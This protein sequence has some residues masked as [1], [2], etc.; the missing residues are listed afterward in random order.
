MDRRTFMKTA[1]VATSTWIFARPSNLT[2]QSG[3]MN[4]AFKLK[5]APTLNAFSAHVGDDPV[6]NIKFAADQGFSAVFDNGLMGRP[7]DQQEQ[8]AKAL[9]DRGMTLGPFVMYTEWQTPTL[10]TG[11]PD[12]RAALLKAVERAIDVAKRTSAKWALVVPGPYD[13]ALEWDYQTAN[14]ISNLRSAAELAAK[15]GL[16]LVIEPL[17]PH[18]HPGQF[19]QRIPQAYQICKAV[20][21]PAVKIVNDLYHQ[22]ITEG[23]LIGNIDRAWDQIAAFHV[24]DNPGRMEPGTGE[25]NYRNIFRHL[26]SKG[27]QGVICMEH[28]NSKGSGKQAEQSLIAAYRAADNF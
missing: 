4:R 3:E 14:V 25:I 16:I 27:Y 17:N 6:E 12:A 10:V 7:K 13:R 9:A 24:G 26:H 5:Y 21:S 15:A 28:G 1:A 19:L 22:Q 18:D 2:A 8:I 20:D 11:R 23:N